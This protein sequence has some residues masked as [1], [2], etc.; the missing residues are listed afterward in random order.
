MSDVSTT[1]R[2]LEI[3][4]SAAGEG[5]GSDDEEDLGEEPEEDEELENENGVAEEVDYSSGSD[6]ENVDNLNAVNDNVEVDGKIWYFVVFYV[7]D[8]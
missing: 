3:K 6:G 4:S 7:C 1:W 5:E 2:P 8:R